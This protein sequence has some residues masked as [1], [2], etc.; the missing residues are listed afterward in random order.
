MSVALAV[1]SRDL[2]RVAVA[3]SQLSDTVAFDHKD[4]T[5]MPV[6]CVTRWFQ[7]FHRKT[8]VLLVLFMDNAFQECPVLVE[9]HVFC[10]NQAKIQ[11]M[12]I[13]PRSIPNVCASIIIQSKVISSIPQPLPLSEDAHLKRKDQ[14]NTMSSIFNDAG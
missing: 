12:Q 1:G 8:Q 5:A 6:R 10:R 2:A 9:M 7:D 13:S 3:H 14:R 11:P 4:K